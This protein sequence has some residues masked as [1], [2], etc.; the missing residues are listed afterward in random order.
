MS[1]LLE[2]NNLSVTLPLPGG[3]LHAVRDVSITLNRG[4]AL[5]IVG[6]SGSGKSMSA[7][8]LMRLL[9]QRA[10]QTGKMLFDGT[11]LTGLSDA[12]YAQQF[13]GHRIAM[14]FQEP[15]TSLNPVYTIGRQLT[16]AAVQFG[17][18]TPTAARA[19]ALA[20]LDRVGIPDPKA[21]MAQYPHQLSGGQRQRVMIAMALM[22]EPEL[23][24]AD[25]PTTA[26][27]VTVQAQIL[28]LLADLR[29]EM[30]MAMILITHDLA[31]VAEQTDRVAV[32]YGGEMIEEGTAK[33][34]MAA[35][36]HPYTQALLT[37]IP[38]MDGPPRRLGA[39]PGTVP[40]LMTPPKGCVFAP[41]CGFVRPDCLEAR[42][43]QLGDADHQRRCV[44]SDAD[45]P[46]SAPAAPIRTDHAE[47]SGGEAVIA[48]RD[49]TQVFTSRKG[50]FGPKH[51]IRA[52]DGVS[53]T[54]KRGETLALV[55]ESGSGKSTLAR[56]MLGLSLP[57]SGTVEMLGRPV[58]DLAPLERAALVQPIFQDPYSS[59]NPRR[60]LAEIIAR[61]LTLRG[62]DDPEACA[63]KTRD[64]ME[65][66]RLPARMLHSYPSQISGGQRQRVA[67]AR[68]LVTRPQALVCDEPTSA[69][70]VSVQA[71]I[72]NLLDELQTELGL[73]CLVI[74]HDMAVVHQVADR[75]AVMLNG[76]LVEEGGCDSV[77]RNPSSDYTARLLAAA[78]QFRPDEMTAPPAQEAT[79]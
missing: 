72:L 36:A 5:G 9:P 67:I 1:K 75:V 64:A 8:A 34:V 27:D 60:T 20:L 59:L 51:E 12:Q 15:M 68:A 3:Q 19:R 58:A 73:S 62:E 52:V 26:L 13:L 63:A 17:S 35:P 14:I 37:A 7:L 33:S 53:L 47:V 79:A 74:T 77:L 45:R 32:M 18:Y 40:S 25:E 4:E 65:M 31:V 71:Q 54:L 46:T 29:R 24:I 22:L 61:P 70:D 10:L 6:E 16:E 2:I 49:I 23:L 76:K 50:M 42:P 44:L 39:I 56:I 38:R 57:T 55:G 66:V 41:R 78:P 11:D 48:A 30:G 21:R 43:P 69:L 28:D